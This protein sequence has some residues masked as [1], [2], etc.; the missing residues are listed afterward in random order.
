M[1]S[2]VQAHRGPDRARLHPS[3]PSSTITIDVPDPGRQ[4]PLHHRQRR[5]GRT[6]PPPTNRA[7]TEGVRRRRALGFARRR[8]WQRRR[9]EGSAGRRRLRRS[10]RQRPDV[11][12]HC[13]VRG[14]LGAGAKPQWQELQGAVAEHEKNRWT[15][16]YTVGWH[17]RLL[18]SR[19][20]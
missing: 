7:P 8:L 19:K 6:S 20:H 9:E 12:R 10:G 5:P 14:K 1:A 15:G 3:P 18:L 4:R 2:P 11:A 17:N 16:Q 13:H